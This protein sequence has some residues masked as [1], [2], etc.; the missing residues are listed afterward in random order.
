[1]GWI[2][3]SSATIRRLRAA[4]LASG[5]GPSALDQIVAARLL[6]S[7]DVISTRRARP[8][9]SNLEHLEQRLRVI[10][11]SGVRWHTPSGGITLWLDLQERSSHRVVQDCARFGVLLEPAS[12][13]TVGGRDD[14][15]LRIPFTLPPPALDRVAD[16]LSQVLAR[17]H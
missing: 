13:Y 15:H 17:A 6:P 3:A 9:A 4:A 10:S 14:R 5:S 2:R 11:P 8:L 1:V 16:V 7:L 12:S